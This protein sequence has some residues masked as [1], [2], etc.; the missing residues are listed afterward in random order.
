MVADDQG[1]TVAES[2]AS[3]V[4][5]QRHQLQ[6]KLH[7]LQEK[8]QQM[9]DLLEKLQQ[10]KSDQMLLDNGQHGTSVLT[11]FTFLFRLFL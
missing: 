5:M 11:L 8:K 6:K 2:E 7:T 4:S 3:T 9:D 1:S 10:L